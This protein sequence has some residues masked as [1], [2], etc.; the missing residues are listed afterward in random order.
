MNKN[1]TKKAFS[2]IEA[3]IVILIIGILIAGITQGSRLVAKSKLNAARA[4]TQTS[5][6]ND[7]EGVMLWIE[8]TL[9]ESFSSSQRIDGAPVNVWNDINT[10]ANK[11]RNFSRATNDN[12]VTYKEFAINNIPSIYFNGSVTSLDS[13][14]NIP[15]IATPSNHFTAFLVS[16]SLLQDSASNQMVFYNGDGFVNG[17]GY[18][19]AGSHLNNFNAVYFGG[20]VFNFLAEPST[21]DPEVTTLI[22]DGVTTSADVNGIAKTVTSPASGPQQTPDGILSIG[23]SYIGDSPWVGYISEIILFE[24]ALTDREKKDIRNYLGKKYNI[25]ISQ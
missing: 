18:M 15:A 17:F 20:V 24:R 5:P 13:V 4:L 23:N 16:Q 10:Q 9:E 7:I 25:A 22:S 12:A 19:R 2:L 1:F 21:S 3:S 14:F 11:K 8:S 6:V